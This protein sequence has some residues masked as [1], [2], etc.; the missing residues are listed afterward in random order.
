VSSRQRWQAILTHGIWAR[1]MDIHQ[2]KR[3]QDIY[4]LCPINA[5]GQ[6][7]NWVAGHYGDHNLGRTGPQRQFRPRP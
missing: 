7:C 6:W 3:E 5:D 2:G 4:V 1:A